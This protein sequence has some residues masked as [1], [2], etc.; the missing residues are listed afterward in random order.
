MSESEEKTSPKL[1]VSVPKTKVSSTSQDMDDDNNKEGGVDRVEE[2]KESE[3]D[4]PV[5]EE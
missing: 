1:R 5:V 2:A 4:E 3:E